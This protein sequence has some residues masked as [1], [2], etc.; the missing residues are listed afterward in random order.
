MYTGNALF[1]LFLLNIISTFLQAILKKKMQGAI[2]VYDK[3]TVSFTT[4]K[5]F[6]V[7]FF[8]C[9]WFILFPYYTLLVKSI[10]ST[11]INNTHIIYTHILAYSHIYN[12][13]KKKTIFLIFMN[14]MQFQKYEHFFFF[15]LFLKFFS[16]SAGEVVNEFELLNFH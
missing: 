11:M 14:K 9:H 6:D 4:F 3:Y 13:T 1:V 10:L 2:F 12:L 16:S 5:T 8:E 15:F 7:C